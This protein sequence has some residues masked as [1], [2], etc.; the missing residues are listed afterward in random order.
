RISVPT[1]ICFLALS[2]AAVLIERKMLPRVTQCVLLGIGAAAVAT[3]GGYLYRSPGLT[4][5]THQT[6]VAPHTAVCLLFLAARAMVLTG[7]VGLIHL[8]IS[9]MLAGSVMRRL[10]PVTV[11]V[12]VL[13]GVCVL[14]GERAGWYSAPFGS[15]LLV[16]NCTLLFALCVWWTATLLHRT[17][18]SGAEVA[19]E[20]TT[21]QERLQASQRRFFAAFQQALVGMAICDKS[22]NVVRANDTLC[23]L[24]GR[25]ADAIVGQSIAAY[26]HADDGA[27]VS[28]RFRDVVAGNQKSADF[29]LRYLRPEGQIVWGRCTFSPIR[30][31][32]SL[33]TLVVIHDI[34]N[35]REVE[36][37]LRESEERL[38][39]AVTTGRLGVWEM[40]LQTQE[41]QLS[42]CCRS[43]HGRS[44]QEPL[45]C[46]ALRAQTHPDDLP[47]YVAAFGESVRNQ[48][49]FEV[50]YRTRWPDGQER[51]LQMRGQPSK[52]ASGEPVRMV[53]VCQD[54]TAR[55]EAEERRLY[56]LEAERAAR[57]EA[58]RVGRMKDEFLATLSHELRTPLNAI[59]GWSQILQGLSPDAEEFKQGLSTIERNARAQAQIIED[60]LDMSRIISGKVRLEMAPVHIRPIIEAAIETVRPSAQGKGIT[61]E[62]DV[63]LTSDLVMADANRLQ[64]VFWNLLSNSIKFTPRGGSVRV[65][66]QEGSELIE[67]RVSDTGTGID[68]AFLPY[69]FD[70]FRQADPSS[71]R[72]HSGLGLGLS[73]V[74][75]LV[76]LHGGTI[77]VQSETGGGGTTF[78]L[79]LPKTSAPSE[80]APAKPGVFYEVGKAPA[81]A[82]PRIDGVR[83]LI[84]DD[85]PDA[86]N[87]A[88]RVMANAH[89][90]VTTADSVPEAIRQL[91]QATYDVLLSDIG[92]PGQDGY[93]LI[94]RVREMAEP[95]I[96][97]IPA[98]A[99]TAY[100]RFDDRERTRRAGYQVHLAKPI[101]PDSLI[102]AVAHLAANP[103]SPS[104]G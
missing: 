81:H 67:I 70:R 9:P 16:A 27:V 54:I 84:V 23:R 71:T 61:L 7:D 44:A 58:E 2:A 104:R 102:S 93:D 103:E 72:K 29:E 75:Q 8:L 85:E 97:N 62:T 60:L 80:P 19:I 88:Q 68:P 6:V 42:E 21:A 1:S 52:A 64:Q 10:L 41:M 66:S 78:T 39:L 15:A 89:A 25:P 11:I 37:K 4:P 92:M 50:E 79:V 30:D 45:T 13:A 87:L 55:R 82:H 94:R 31:G 48:T 18:R 12:P 26:T 46:E 32:D 100:A 56:F 99:L 38:Q 77:S 14:A 96:A 95:A 69:V 74:K 91:E 24:I 63:R 5:A 20:R 101:E 57:S 3:L 35:Q 22:G 65:S 47:R 73:I 34:T 83:V 98:I 51:W 36:Q 17:E 59:M 53:G 90:A 49:P 86:R 76:D 28:T 33:S 43:L 40:N